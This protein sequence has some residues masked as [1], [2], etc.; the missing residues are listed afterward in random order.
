MTIEKP[1]FEESV[2]GNKISETY[3]ILNGIADLYGMKD[4]ESVIKKESLRKDLTK[5]L[6]KTRQMEAI[7]YIL[8]ERAEKDKY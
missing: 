1:A 4:M 6:P 2:R 5:I 3:L 8:K 7:N